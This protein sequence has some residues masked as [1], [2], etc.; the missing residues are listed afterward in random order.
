MIES[1][2]ASNVDAWTEKHYESSCG[3]LCALMKDY[4]ETASSLYAGRPE[5]ISRMLL[6]VLE[7]WVAL[8]KA[9]VFEIPMLRGY[10]PEIPLQIYQALLLGSRGDMARLHRTEEYV[11][12][13]Q[14]PAQGKKKPS[15]FRSY[16]ERESF[17]VQYFAASIEQQNLL[18]SIEADA[19]TARQA[20][21]EE[22]EQLR[23]EYHDLTE[24]YQRGTCQEV[25]QEVDGIRYTEHAPHCNRCYLLQRAQNLAIS[26]HEWPLSANPLEAQA[27]V[28]ELAIP[29]VFAEWRDATLYLLNDVLRCEG[30]SSLDTG[31]QTLYPLRSYEELA[32]YSKPG[33]WRVHLLSVVKPNAVTHR[34][35]KN[36]AM[37][38]MSD[39]CVNNGLR[40][41]YFDETRQV[42]LLGEM[43]PTLDISKRCTFQVS[44]RSEPLQ[45][46]LK[47]NYLCPDGVTPNE[48]V[49]CQSKCPEHMTVGEFKALA[50]LPFGCRTQWMSVLLQLVLPGIDLNKTET[51]TFLLQISLQA[52]PNCPEEPTVSRRSHAR[53]DNAVFAREMH[54]H[55]LASVLRIRENWESH[56]ALWTYTFL[57]A[58]LLSMVEQELRELF[59]GF[60]HLCRTISYQWLVKLRQRAHQ[61]T[62]DQ[63]RTELQRIVLDISLIHVDSFNV[64]DG[65]L[66]RILA[67]P[68]ESSMLVEASIYI[69][70]NANLLGAEAL[71]LQQVMHDRWKH[72]LHRARPFFVKELTSGK[73]HASLN[74]AIKRCWPAFTADAVWRIAPSTCHWFETTCSQ[75]TVHLEILTGRLLVD[76]QP[77]SRLPHEYEAHGSYQRLFGCSAMDV[78]PSPQTG[79]QFCSIKDFEGHTVHF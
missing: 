56:T 21:R 16:G 15:V 31:P 17:P 30:S 6:V 41:R 62:D 29:R 72:T 59:L 68:Q 28:F 12:K 73:G 35:Q 54:K 23:R 65:F 5:G 19:T 27:T 63:Q 45:H 11:K 1:W 66:C 74:L 22:F 53:L 38:T 75:S 61:E 44:G 9:A 24:R 37:S 78:M 25:E 79:M 64:D 46:F 47:R 13:R 36:I 57:A 14:S 50:T 69:F 10:S 7:L 49:A 3:S 70:N 77:L 42:F 52:G 26:V 39:V 4:H 71:S 76:G 67:E 48:V 33:H 8:D 58:R 2:V 51:A 32:K 40:F 43:T 34:E 55:L 18:R 60:L 20:K